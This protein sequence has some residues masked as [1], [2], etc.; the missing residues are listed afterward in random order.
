[1]SE[2]LFRDSAQAAWLALMYADMPDV[3]PARAAMARCF[4]KQNIEWM[5]GGNDVPAGKATSFSF[6]VGFSGAGCVLAQ[7]NF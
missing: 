3:T 2:G 6:Q 7:L 4:A 5:L 1:M